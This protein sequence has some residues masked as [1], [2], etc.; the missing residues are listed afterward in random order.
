MSLAA[1]AVARAIVV[2]SLL[3]AGPAGAGALTAGAATVRIAVPPGTPLAGYGAVARRSLV[4]DLLGRRPHAFWFRSHEGEAD[5]I[6][7]RALVLEHDGARLAWIAT[8]LIA[9]DGRLAAAVVTRL[10]RELG[11]PTTVIVSASH[12]H[13]GPGAFAD[14][15]VMGFVAVDRPDAEVRDA[16]VAALVDAAR[17]AHAART[18]AR[19]GVAAG[20]APDLT[21]SR[22]DA[23]VDRELVVLKITA[24]AG[25]PIALVWNFAI[26]PTMYGARNLRLSADVTGLAS[27][28]LE[29]WLGVPALFVNGAV[30]DVSPRRH[31]GDA[32]HEVAETLATTTRAL[33]QRARVSDAGPPIVR[34]TRVSL[35]RPALSLRNCVGA[36]VP[37]ALAIPVGSTFPDTATLT[38]VA[39]GDAAWVTIPG[40]LQAAL[41]E[42]V[43]RAA[44]A[45]WRHPF[46]AGLSNDYLGYFVGRAEYDRVTYV[47]CASLYG[48]EA[49]ERLAA[50]ASGLL[51]GL[52]DQR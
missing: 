4:P 13:S 10:E 14:S 51:R 1:R 17:R 27:G 16:V 32:A 25:Q 50:A 22:V 35:G 29:R 6:R 21:R 30:G 37:R 40:E 43:K 44:P 3:A 23:R 38:A 47:T 5:P 20:Q 28:T 26:H 41:G 8:D 15:E 19:I 12:T 39:V 2:A 49:G 42:R 46:V 34:T 45:R 11:E 24:A 18:R 7:A 9:V 52:G 36:W 33:W 31:G 48:P